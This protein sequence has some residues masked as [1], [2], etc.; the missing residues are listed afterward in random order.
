MAKDAETGNYFVSHPTRMRVNFFPMDEASDYV[1]SVILIVLSIV[2]NALWQDFGAFAWLIGFVLWIITMWPVVPSKEERLYYLVFIAPFRELYQ[3][4]KK[5]VIWKNGQKEKFPYEVHEFGKMGLIYDT[6]KQTYSMVFGMT[7]SAAST[8]SLLGQYGHNAQIAEILRRAS[9]STGLR[10]LQVTFGYDI[11]PE[12]PLAVRYILSEMGDINVMLPEA[13]M[14]DKPVE[15]Y[16]AKDKREVALRQIANEMEMMALDASSVTMVYVITMQN[17]RVFRKILRSGEFYSHQVRRQSLIR[18]KETL[19]TLLRT[20]AQGIE[21]YDGD[22]AEEYLRKCRDIAH[23]YEYCGLI[24]QQL[25]AGEEGSEQD[26]LLTDEEK[27]KILHAPN[28]HIIANQDSLTMDG[29]SGS[30]VRITEFPLDQPPVNYVREYSSVFNLPAPFFSVNVTGKTKKGSVQS[31]TKETTNTLT[32]AARTMTGRQKRGVA[33]E[34]METEREAEERR[35]R[36]SYTID[37]KPSVAILA[38]DDENGRDNL[39][40]QVLATIDQLKEKGLGPVQVTGR[41]RQF[42]EVLSAITHIP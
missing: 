22:Q 12:N 5:G 15:D 20:V 4:Y 19:T 35:L 28:E 40:L 17:N 6:S 10:G 27:V 36:A 31:F 8:L 13:L 33:Q 25:A 24:N 1:W 37:F 14:N 41:F 2:F 9:A 23:Y 29:T 34:E 26:E 11:R 16:T 32:D 39:D 30:V 18:I 42:N 3:M 21:M 38:A 7:G